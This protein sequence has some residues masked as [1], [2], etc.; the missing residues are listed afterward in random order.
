MKGVNNQT[1]CKRCSHHVQAHCSDSGHC[2]CGCFGF[3]PI[4]MEP[5]YYLQDSRQ[6]VGNSMLWWR[7]DGQG[8]CCDVREAEV[9]S[10]KEAYAQH[11]M[12]GTDIPWPKPYID[13]R[14]AHHIDFQKCDR[15]LMLAAYAPDGEVIK[16]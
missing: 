7:R 1:T 16:P 10:K 2:T 12:R 14:V 13:Q 5:L 9:Y 4:S 3:E 11:A 8:Y 6:T 15:E